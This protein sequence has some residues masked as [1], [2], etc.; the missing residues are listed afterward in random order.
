MGLKIS[1]K[2]SKEQREILDMLTKDYETP[3]SI[4]LRRKTS[5][6]AVY[7]TINKLK[8]NGIIIKNI[9][10]KDNNSPQSL[11]NRLKKKD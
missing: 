5:I 11:T 9:K 3:K 1:S 6:S 4:A 8:K 10:R 2:L 7:K